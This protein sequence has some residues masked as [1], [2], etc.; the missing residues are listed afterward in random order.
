VNWGDD[1]ESVFLQFTAGGGPRLTIDA[2]VLSEATS[3]TVELSLMPGAE[4]GRVLSQTG[5]FLIDQG[6]QRLTLWSASG[7]SVVFDFCA[8][9]GGSCLAADAWVHL[10]FRVEGEEVRVYRGG[11]LVDQGAVPGGLTAG[12][13]PTEIGTR[14]GIEGFGGRL[15]MLR[16]SGGSQ[17]D[18][19]THEP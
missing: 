14:E 16:F 12:S 8:D 13:A 17:L 5:R 15:R 9:A 11:A 6:G 1:T 3:L 4:G 7:E 2:P 19:L 18:F 10:A